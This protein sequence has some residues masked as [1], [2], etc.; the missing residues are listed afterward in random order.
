LKTH[1][2]YKNFLQ[3]YERAHE[4]LDKDDVIEPSVTHTLRSYGCVK[5]VL[6]DYE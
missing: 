5:M 3:D 4:V 2:H 1:A 6:K